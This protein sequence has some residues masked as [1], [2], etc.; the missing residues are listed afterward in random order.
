MTPNFKQ[1]RAWVLHRFPGWQFA[2]DLVQ[3]I[4]LK[5]LE[6]RKSNY[7][8]LYCDFLRKY[9]DK[10]KL[11]QYYDGKDMK[12]TTED[13]IIFKIDSER[14]PIK[15]YEKH[16]LKRIKKEITLPVV[17]G[18]WMDAL[19][20]GIKLRDLEYSFIVATLKA[21]KGNRTHA[22]IVLGISLRSIRNKI[23]EMKSIGFFKS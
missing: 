2:D 21:V 20:V 10:G 14:L 5:R 16:R 1:I 3:W 12:A 19:P 6:G 18:G 22:A 23:N 11:S 4:C 15:I 13:D 8:F 17:Q 9:G 7:Y